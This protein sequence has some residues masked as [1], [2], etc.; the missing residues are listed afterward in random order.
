[1]VYAILRLCH[2]YCWQNA[3]FVMGHTGGAM[4]K[5]ET[6]AETHDEICFF[7]TPD[8]AS[9]TGLKC[10]RCTFRDDLES[11]CYRCSTPFDLMS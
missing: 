4:L 1:M 6:E 9:E 5:P 11:L 8:Y 3:S 2:M 10:M 7:G